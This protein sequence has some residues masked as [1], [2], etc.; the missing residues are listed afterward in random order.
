MFLVKVIR[1]SKQRMP[2]RWK[3]IENRDIGSRRGSTTSLHR[4]WGSNRLP[5]PVK[6]ILVMKLAVIV[7]PTLVFPRH[8]VWMILSI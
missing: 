8:M 7:V 4:L 6:T 2:L 5:S 1:S 3:V